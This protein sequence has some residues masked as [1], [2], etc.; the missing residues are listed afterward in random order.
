MKIDKQ[1]IINFY[2]LLQQR[3]DS[4]IERHIPQDVRTALS[5]DS[6]KRLLAWLLGLF[7]LFFVWSCLSPVD[8][9]VRAEGRI[10][11]AGRAQIV[12]HLEGGIVT[13]ILVQEGQSV[14]AGEV[15][16]RLS[17][18]QANTSAQQSQN[19]FWT[20]KAQQAR[21]EA[22]A[23]GIDQ[24]TFNDDIPGEYRKLEF[25]VF[26]ERN[27][28]NQSERNVITQQINQRQSELSE[29]Q[30]RATSLATEVELSRKQSTL[31]EGLYKSG[32]AS[33]I[34]MLDAQGRTQR[35]QT[36]YNDVRGSIPRLQAAVA[37]AKAKLTESIA[38]QKTEAKTELTQIS[39]EIERLSAAVDND[40]DRLARTEVRAPMS[41]YINRLNFNTI[42]GVIKPGEAVLEI[43]PS[44]GP[45]A[46]EAHVRPDDRAS[47]RPGL[48]TRVMVGAYDYAVYGALVGKVVEVSADTVPD[49]HGQRYYRV[50]IKTDGNEGALARQSL[51]PGMTAHADVV[52]GQRRV[53]SYL[54]SPLLKFTQ[55]AMRE[56]T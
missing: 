13:E 2:Q 5:Q 16:M 56:P 22:E 1:K 47:L 11:A 36:Q 6:D 46:V 26:Q 39:E 21:L 34:E 38:K 37:E 44:E 9:I 41:G 18:L 45:V 7:M 48:E 23:Q 20:I 51:L 29:A 32:A 12:Q 30:T 42:G 28:R 31:L 27:A 17:N 53:I 14:K 8:R 19:R 33:Q 25:D 52:L 40:Q 49:E 15:L 54:V 50:L 43:T 3:A 4:F 24:I 55:R 10:I 35:L